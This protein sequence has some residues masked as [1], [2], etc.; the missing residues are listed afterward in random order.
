MST[1]ITAEQLI[2]AERTVRYGR[3]LERPEVFPT[4]E[5][6]QYIID[7]AMS[8]LVR[9]LYRKYMVSTHTPRGERSD[10]HELCLKNFPQYLK[11]I[12]REDALEAIYDDMTTAPEASIKLVIECQLFDAER[13]LNLMDDGDVL[14]AIACLEAYQP[15]YTYADLAPMRH[16]AHAVQDLAPVGTIKKVR[17]IFG[18]EVKYICADGHTNPSGTEFCETCGRDINGLDRTLRATADAYISRVHTLEKML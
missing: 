5:N 7:N 2:V 4:A 1:E 8:P 16:L 12:N 3:Q 18:S 17:G 14:T 15:T 11:V 13:I 10:F 9:Q 6:W